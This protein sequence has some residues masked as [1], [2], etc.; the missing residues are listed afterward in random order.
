MFRITPVTLLL[1]PLVASAQDMPLFTFTVEGEGWV[2]ADG[3]K[4]D[5]EFSVLERQVAK[6]WFTETQITIGGDRFRT[7]YY[8]NFPGEPPLGEKPDFAKKKRPRSDFLTAAVFT[9]DKG[10]VYVGFSSE[11][12]VWAFTP[13]SDGKLT[14]GTPYAPLRF[15]KGYD[16]SKEALEELKG[17]PPRAEVSALLLDP[18]GRL[19]AA[20]PNDLQV[21]D[22]TGRL[23]GVLELPEMGKGKRVEIL[24]WEGPKQDVLA[25]WAGEQKWTRKMKPNGR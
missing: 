21:F 9:A 14:N 16:N 11:T 23:S 1:L 18:S 4:P 5:N 20:T 10:T 24:R 22:P 13:D 2:K 7:E 25:A 6:G 15:R 3:K 17:N 8:N 12:A 19:Y